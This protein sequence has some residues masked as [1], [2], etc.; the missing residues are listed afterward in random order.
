MQVAEQGTGSCVPDVHQ[1]M[2]LL[3][4][5]WA[6][7][8]ELYKLHKSYHRS[9]FPPFPVL[10][11]PLWCFFRVPIVFGDL[12]MHLKCSCPFWGAKENRTMEP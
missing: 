10:L 7:C 11:E 5:S 12:T 8:A 4:L 1:M 3:L 9:F 2:G 6:W